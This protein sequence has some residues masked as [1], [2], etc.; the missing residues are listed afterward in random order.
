MMD[1]LRLNG[2]LSTLSLPRCEPV[3]NTDYTIYFLYRF[4]R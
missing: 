3:C 2:M 1:R 4:I